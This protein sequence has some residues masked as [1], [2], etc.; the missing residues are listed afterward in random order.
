[1]KLVVWGKS[2]KWAFNG[3]FTSHLLQEIG[4]FDLIERDSSGIEPEHRCQRERVE[5]AF[6]GDLLRHLNPESG[7]IDLIEHGFGVIEYEKPIS[8]IFP[9]CGS[10]TNRRALRR[11]CLDANSA[12]MSRVRQEGDSVRINRGPSSAKARSPP[13]GLHVASLHAPPHHV[14]PSHGIWVPSMP[15]IAVAL[16]NCHCPPRRYHSTTETDCLRTVA[17][18][19]VT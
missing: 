16:K 5:K 4:S 2:V 15:L 3:L 6:N 10:I 7:S 13:G 18:V 9:Q 8:L 12:Q 1:M 17:G 19:P 11:A 14:K